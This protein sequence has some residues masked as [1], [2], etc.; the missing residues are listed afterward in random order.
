MKV[1]HCFPHDQFEQLRFVTRE[2]EIRVLCF[3]SGNHNGYFA[4]VPKHS[5]VI[6]NSRV[7]SIGR[8]KINV[9]V[10]DVRCFNVPVGQLTQRVNWVGGAD[11]EYQVVGYVSSLA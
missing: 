11:P 1:V 2:L 8:H 10:K 5:Q 4:R 3:K 9:V 7:Y 6:F